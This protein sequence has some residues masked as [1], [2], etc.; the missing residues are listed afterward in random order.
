MALDGYCFRD[1]TLAGHK[2]LV[3]FAFDQF[4]LE[5]LLLPVGHVGDWNVEKTLFLVVGDEDVVRQ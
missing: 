3:V 4:F 2:L 1:C 5:C